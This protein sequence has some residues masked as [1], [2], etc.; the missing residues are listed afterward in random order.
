MFGLL[1]SHE[2]VH[3]LSTF[4]RKY[5]YLN[6]KPLIIDLYWSRVHFHA[7]LAH[8]RSVAQKVFQSRHGDAIIKK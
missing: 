3:E 2:C 5:L 1:Y 7:E 8:V 4:L 6:L